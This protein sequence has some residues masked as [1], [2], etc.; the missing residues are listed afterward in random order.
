MSNAC[1]KITLVLALL[2]ACK[3]DSFRNGNS[4]PPP[5]TLPVVTQPPPNVCVRKTN[6]RTLTTLVNLSDPAPQISYEIWVEDC[7]GSLTDLNGKSLGFD[8]DANVT[9]FSSDISA[10]VAPSNNLS[11]IQNLVLV[12]D[13]TQDLFGNHSQ[14]QEVFAHWRVQSL[15]L[16]TATTRIILT[17]KLL[18][19]TKMT[20]RLNANSKTIPT[21][22]KIG[23]DVNVATSEITYR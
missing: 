18:A 17:I 12:S 8:I 10:T 11:A 6:A 7:V 2:P 4:T 23:D 1:K 22:L 14:G 3:S 15:S 20:N 9:P 5:T 19:G 13:Q 16:P 21:L